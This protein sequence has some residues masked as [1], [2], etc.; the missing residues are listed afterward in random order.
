MNSDET[1]EALKIAIS[2]AILGWDPTHGSLRQVK[3]ALTAH[4]RAIR[5][6]ALRLAAEAAASQEFGDRDGKFI[7]DWM[8][9]EWAEQASGWLDT[10]A[11]LIESEARG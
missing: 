8:P 4:E 9:D 7:L 5:A 10:L 3:D 6:E 1:R 11:D 2:D